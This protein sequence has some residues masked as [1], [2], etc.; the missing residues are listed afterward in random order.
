MRES[1]LYV[2]E[3]S[4]H[5][6]CPHH[7]FR[8]V[9]TVSWLL[10]FDQL[11]LCH[12]YWCME[13]SVLVQWLPSAWERFSHPGQIK[14]PAL[15]SFIGLSELF[16]IQQNNICSSC[17]ICPINPL[18]SAD[19]CVACRSMAAFTWHQ[20]VKWLHT[21]CQTSLLDRWQHFMVWWQ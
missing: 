11:H 12:S 3:G 16:Y 21:A 14:T 8:S 15:Q 20:P 13:C 5:L 4:A 17:P 1:L 19:V 7:L 10:E 2:V 9:Q 18:W 6:S